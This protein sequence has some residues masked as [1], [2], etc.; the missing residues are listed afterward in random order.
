MGLLGVGHHQLGIDRAQLGDDRGL[1]RDGSFQ[2]RVGRRDRGLQDTK[3]TSPLAHGPH[4]QA[5]SATSGVNCCP[6]RQ[7]V[8]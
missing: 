8:T 4:G 3:Q 7:A 6:Q 2:I 5:A 1:H